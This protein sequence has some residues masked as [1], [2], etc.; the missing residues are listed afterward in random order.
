MS[1]L[2]KLINKFPNKKWDWKALS[3]HPEITMECVESHPEHPWDW[4]T[5]SDIMNLLWNNRK[6]SR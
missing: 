4:Y 3:K 1:L 2:I 6:V 5:L